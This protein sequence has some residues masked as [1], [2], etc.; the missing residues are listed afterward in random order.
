MPLVRYLQRG[1]LPIHAW[2][3]FAL[4]DN[5]TPP[6]APPLKPE[7]SGPPT[8][9]QPE[10]AL[11]PKISP[12]PLP[13]EIRPQYCGPV[14]SWLAQ[15][16]L[17]LAIIFVA[18]LALV[19][20]EAL[21]VSAR[22]ERFSF[23]SDAIDAAGAVDLTGLKT[24]SP[25]VLLYLML[26][27]GGA[28]ASLGFGVALLWSAELRESPQL[29]I[30]FFGITRRPMPALRGMDLVATLI[31]I[32]AF[33]RLNMLL[34]MLLGMEHASNKSAVQAISMALFDCAIIGGI[35]IAVALARA[36]ARGPHGSNGFWP[37]WA[38][39]PTAG[40]RPL[41]KDLILG[42]GC[43]PLVLWV[44]WACKMISDTA[45]RA[46]GSEP[47][48]HPII[49]E[50]AREHDPFV[51]A[52][53]LATGIFGAAILEEILFRGI[54]YNILRRYFGRWTG[55]LLAALLFAIVHGLKSDLLGLLVLGLTLT[56]LYDR[57]GRLVSSITLHAVNNAMS[58]MVVLFGLK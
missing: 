8:E 46:M 13:S 45:L 10:G 30:I 50:L 54:L 51:I 57:T 41:W 4:T 5:P 37:F 21:Q 56:W 6:S 29:R 23:E 19:G 17:P 14:E 1:A 32:Y 36:R 11:S 7:S 28:L 25:V 38:L 48:K 16:T 24:T 31:G 15:N 43:Y 47:D 27:V 49:P 26:F 20:V 52:V 55:A 44:V 42:A 39:P 2:K 3:T 33:L 34:A 9:L 12:V 18:L 22:F 35:M 40:G 53:Y 58:L